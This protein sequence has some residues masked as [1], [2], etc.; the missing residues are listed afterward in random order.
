[1]ASH[2]S[3]RRSKHPRRNLFQVFFRILLGLMPV[4]AGGVAYIRVGGPLRG[5]AALQYAYERFA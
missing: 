2:H 3:I 4:I 5:S 1:M